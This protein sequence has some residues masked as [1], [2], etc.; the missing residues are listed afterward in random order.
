VSENKLPDAFVLLKQALAETKSAPTDK[1]RLAG[2][3]KAFE[4]CF[5]Y[6]W[7]N[8]K[9]AAQ[10]AGMEVYSPRDCLKAGAQLGLIEDLEKWNRFLNTRNLTVHDY[11]GV[12]DREFSA[13]AREFLDELKKVFGY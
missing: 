4:V 5:E 9:R 6:S 3:I 2:L 13:V 7:K 12:D 11:I 1:V 10:E 8:F